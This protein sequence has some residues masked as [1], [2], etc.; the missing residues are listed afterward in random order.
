MGPALGPT[1]PTRRVELSQLNSGQLQKT[2]TSELLR[3]AITAGV[4]ALINWLVDGCGARMPSYV[5][6]CA[7]LLLASKH[8][9]IT[10]IGGSELTLVWGSDHHGW[11][12]R[13]G[14][15]LG[16]HPIINSFL[17]VW[18]D[19]DKHYLNLIDLRSFA[20]KFSYLLICLL[21]H[22]KLY[23]QAGEKALREKVPA[24]TPDDLNS[25]HW[26][27]MVEEKNQLMNVVL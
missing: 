4:L 10:M 6:F 16:R 13:T 21:I 14:S 12:V 2:L 18:L 9:Q 23:S 24:G 25:V 11:R 15:A 26:T 8:C 27:N 22:S 20:L 3:L 17:I 19:S 7:S 1:D 5:S